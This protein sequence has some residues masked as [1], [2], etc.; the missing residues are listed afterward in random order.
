MRQ[1]T[2]LGTYTYDTDA[3]MTRVVNRAIDGS[4]RVEFHSG[5]IATVQHVQE[6]ELL[7]AA[8]RI[9]P[10]VTVAQGGYDSTTTTASY[11]L[12]NN[13][14]VAGRLTVSTGQ[15]YEGTRTEAGYSGRV[16]LLPP[17]ALEPSVSLAWVRLPYGD[18][19]ARL[20]ANRVTWTPTTRLFV[21]SLMQF[22]VDAKTLSSSVRL[23]WEYRLGSDLFVVYSDGRETRTP[24][25]PGLLNRTFAIKATRLFRF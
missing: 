12:A 17:F 7:P 4:F 14:R 5:D 25:F 23:R 16:A 3:G 1:L 22:N 13:R 9:A 6:Y 20:L 11:S 19:E 2:W 24:G 10:R 8:F 21:S 18:F 15:F